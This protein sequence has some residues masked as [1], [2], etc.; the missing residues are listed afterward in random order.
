MAKPYSHLRAQMATD[1]QQQAVD[2]A[3]ALL[4]DDLDRAALR[5]YAVWFRHTY[6]TASVVPLYSWQLLASYPEGRA[7]QAVA[8][9][10]AGRAG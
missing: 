3:H 4:A 5:A 8:R 9:H 2:K 10:C 7:A 1:A 6:P